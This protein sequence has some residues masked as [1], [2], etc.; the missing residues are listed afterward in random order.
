[1][2]D[3]INKLILPDQ[4][5]AF[6]FPR[7][8]LAE[9]NRYKGTLL[10]GMVANFL[11]V[12]EPDLLLSMPDKSLVKPLRFNFDEGEI[13]V[14]PNAEWN[15]ALSWLHVVL[16]ASGSGKTRLLMQELLKRFGLLL[17]ASVKGNG[18]AA[19]RL[20]LFGVPNMRPLQDL[21]KIVAN[22]SSK[23]NDNRTKNTGLPG[24]YANP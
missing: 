17:I 16:G 18:G 6:E 23:I 15:L 10:P 11:N 1:M 4:V 24:R 13:V 12:N 7:V 3:T 5:T 20:H 2:D 19:V 21:E 9:N 22:V 8:A 14:D